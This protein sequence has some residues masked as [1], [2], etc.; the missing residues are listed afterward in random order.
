LKYII[1]IVVLL[2]VTTIFFITR[3]DPGYVSGESVSGTGQVTTPVVD[4]GDDKTEKTDDET[5]RRAEMT[6][7]FERLNKARRNLESLLNRLKALLWG[8]ELPREERDAISETMKNGYGL[9]KH[10]KLMGAYPGVKEI[11][12]E[13]SQV[14]FVYSQLK[15]IEE[16]Y[17]NR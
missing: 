7:E 9:L 10:K 4:A 11:S 14:E 12:D 17:R 16:K 6:A 1:G 3:P 15:A 5:I 13:L 2:L 8:L